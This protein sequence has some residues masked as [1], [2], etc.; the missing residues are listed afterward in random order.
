MAAIDPQNH[1]HKY[2]FVS[3]QY[4]NVLFRKFKNVGGAMY[5]FICIYCYQ[6]L[7]VTRWDMLA[8][9]REG[10]FPVKVKK[11]VVLNITPPPITPRRRTNRPPDNGEYD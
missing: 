7:E 10:I 11:E 9:W 3:V 6:N 2:K 1:K 8:M 5:H 4:S